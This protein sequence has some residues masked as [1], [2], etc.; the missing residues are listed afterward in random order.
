[1]T[2]VSWFLSP[3]VLDRH[4][5]FAELGKGGI[6]GC[7]AFGTVHRGVWIPEGENVKIPVAIKVLNEGTSANANK[8]ILEEAY[9]MAS[10]EHPNLLQ[11]LAICIKSQVSLS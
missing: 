1:M 8:E 9:I 10:L 5:F 6:L 3:W 11:L 4:F 7:G 2:N